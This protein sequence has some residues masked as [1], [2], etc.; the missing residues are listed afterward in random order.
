MLFACVYVYCTRYSAYLLI[1]FANAQKPICN[2]L[3]Y[4]KKANERSEHCRIPFENVSC[5]NHFCIQQKIK[6]LGGNE[7]VKQHLFQFIFMAWQIFLVPKT[8]TV[9]NRKFMKKWRIC[10]DILL[11]S[12]KVMT[13]VDC[14]YLERVFLMNISSSKRNR[15]RPKHSFKL[16]NLFVTTFP[17]Y[18]LHWSGSYFICHFWGYDVFG[19][20][21][22]PTNFLLSTWMN[23]NFILWSIALKL[24]YLWSSQ[25]YRTNIAFLP[26]G[27]GRHLPKHR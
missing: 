1:F 16:M 6:M 12:Q 10:I 15:Y 21:E 25:S 2:T 14:I 22:M 20:R 19:C 27:A 9:L 3:A 18:E 23:A 17:V 13:I 11:G 4:K 5:N 26:D 7:N 24:T 8:L